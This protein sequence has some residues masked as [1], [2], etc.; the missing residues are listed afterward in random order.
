MLLLNRKIDEA[1]LIGP[2]IRIIVTRIAHGTV[3]LGIEAPKSTQILR[4]EINELP[5][6]QPE[7]KQGH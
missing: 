7:A 5:K 4:E 1:I 6:V 2:D 3:R